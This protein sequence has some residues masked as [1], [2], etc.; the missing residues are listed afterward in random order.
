MNLGQILPF[1]QIGVSVLLIVVI[2]LQQKG[3]GLSSA[4]GGSGG[5]YRTK[6]GF[7]RVLMIGT[8]VLAITFVVLSI[9][10][11]IFHAS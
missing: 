2:L 6:R 8:V 11:I 3:A 9:L 7:E 4:F 10:N 1:I 5:F